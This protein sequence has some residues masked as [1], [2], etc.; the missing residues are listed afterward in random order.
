MLTNMSRT[1]VVGG[2]MVLLAVMVGVS[3]A[4]SASLPTTAALLV[5]GVAPGVVAFFVGG[6][7]S[8]SMTEILHALETK[9]GG[10]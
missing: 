4:M 1:L 9:D 2:S 5:L 10:R 8:Q 6:A 7:P 3:F